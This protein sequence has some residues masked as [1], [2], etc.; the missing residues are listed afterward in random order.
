M[1]RKRSCDESSVL[2]CGLGL[3]G[4]V[5]GNTVA[6]TTTNPFGNGSLANA[7]T[8]VNTTPNLTTI[9]FNIPGGGNQLIRPTAS[10]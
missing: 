10:T 4:N 5:V 7:I 8:C 9:V 2:N 3:G 1:L 6:V